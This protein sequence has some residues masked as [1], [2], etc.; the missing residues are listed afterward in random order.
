[1]TPRS[2]T[3]AIFAR[4]IPALSWLRGYTRADFNADLIAGTITAILLVPQAM[5]YAL[6]AGL[7]PQVGL[8]ASVVAP[9][10]YAFIGSSRTLS[11][12]PVSV[13]AIMVATTLASAGL[14]GG[15]QDLSNALVLALEIGVILLAMAAM[16]LGAIVNFL[17]HPVLSGFTS[18]A[19]IVI[20]LT[21][22]APLLGIS[23]GPTTTSHEVFAAIV[24]NIHN[25]KLATLAVGAA[26]IVLLLLAENPLQR[27]LRRLSDQEW[28]G[29]L[30]RTGPLLV[31]LLATFAAV[32]LELDKTYGVSTVG[33]IPQGLANV[34]LGFLQQ[35]TWIA[36][37]PSAALIAFIGYV[38][39]ISIAKILAN[40]RRQ[41]INANQEL[42]GLGAANIAA[43]LTGGMPVAGGFGRTMVNYAAGARTQMASVITALLIGGTLL[44]LAEFFARLPKA[45]LGAVIVV[46]VARLIDISTLR[47]AW[48]YQ[49]SDAAV[50]L[51]TLA[52]VLL[53]GIEV[54]LVNGI[55]LSLVVYV[56]RGS[57]PHM[58][59]VGRVPDTEHFRNI[60]RHAVETWPSLALVR[61]DES[62]TFT[63]IG[64]VEDFIAAHIARQ[65]EVKH[66]VLVCNAVNHID[67]SALEA[68]ERLIASLREAGVTVHLAEV[69]GPVLDALARV[70][71]SLHLAPGKVFFRTVDAVTALAP[72]DSG[73][74][75]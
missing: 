45:A 4:G 47:H 53:L 58:A 52:S 31:V 30:A 71:F 36:L 24:T 18:G 44:W 21:Q 64:V 28:V 60:N 26:S 9:I 46:A 73:P 43:A 70:D 72:A 61:V 48:R 68:L 5:A 51:V 12:G 16:R 8:Y 38:E 56:W 32:T 62:L 29:A 20:L 10:A 41:R 75:T 69:K 1:L 34:D 39:S 42:A 49:R 15:G 13:A 33:T 54:G 40:R 67:S 2:D 35:D 65:P 59:I 6:L 17:S 7:P 55:L 50:L 74:T 14:S 63:N 3:L 23:A 11:V 57:R 27:L 25:T 22:V 19:A 66:V 37:L